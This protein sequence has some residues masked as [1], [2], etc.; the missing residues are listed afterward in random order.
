MAR[1]ETSA[2]NGRQLSE[3]RNFA[4]N[5]PHIISPLVGSPS[6]RL[7]QPAKARQPA[8]DCLRDGAREA[9]AAEGVAATSPD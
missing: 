7:R 2:L 9:D 4:R 6:N 3:V 5:N 1:C 8:D